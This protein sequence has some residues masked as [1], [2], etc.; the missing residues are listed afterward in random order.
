[1]TEP[2]DFQSKLEINQ[3]FTSLIPLI[4]QRR[5]LPVAPGSDFAL[6][7]A[8]LP[9]PDINQ[10]AW[11]LRFVALDH[12]ESLR[13]HAAFAP[14]GQSRWHVHAPW[15]QLR[16]ALEA[17]SQLVWMIGPDDR[18]TRLQRLLRFTFD[19]N[20]SYKLALDL[21]HHPKKAAQ[22]AKYQQIASGFE[23]AAAH[24]TGKDANRIRTPI[25]MVDCITESARLSHSVGFPRT[26]ELS[27]RIAAGYAHG[28]P[29]AHLTTGN[30][31]DLGS[32]DE[33]RTQFAGSINL[34]YVRMMTII[35]TG[36]IQYG[37]HLIHQRSGREDKLRMY[38]FTEE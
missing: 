18:D 37:D 13:D 38:A 35:T 16:A 28:R 1:M 19:D 27:W 15:T 31:V 29:W 12:M 34:P 9:E 4:S 7:E 21:T 3:C 33:L 20:A 8:Q 5:M 26:A 24:W 22:L 10:A 14:D 23:T 25:N 6:D 2:T 30:L 32:V 36:T 11:L 17:A